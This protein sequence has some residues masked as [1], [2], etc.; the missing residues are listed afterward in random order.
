[1]NASI[2]DQYDNENICSEIMYSEFDE[3]PYALFDITTLQ[4]HVET[5][6]EINDINYESVGFSISSLST[7]NNIITVNLGFESSID[8][9]HFKLIVTLLNGNTLVS[10]IY[11]YK[12]ENVYY[13]SRAAQADGYELK[14]DHELN[15]NLISIE[16]YNTLIQENIKI[17]SDFNNQ[18]TPNNELADTQINAPS[19]SSAKKTTVV[20][21][22][23]W[24]DGTN[25][26]PLKDTLVK[27]YIEWPFEFG[28]SCSNTATLTTYTDDYGEYSFTFS[29][30]EEVQVNVQILSEGK[31]ILVK[32]NWISQS[33]RTSTP[34]QTLSP[35]ETASFYYFL[36]NESTT[37]KAFQVCQALI[38]GA[39]YV[40]DMGATVPDSTCY[41]P[42]DGDYYDGAINITEEAVEY[43]DIILHEYGHRLQE[44]FGISNNPGGNHIINEDQ[45]ANHGKDKGIRLAWGEGWPTCFAILVTQYYGSTLENIKDIN[46]N[47]YNS[48]SYD[49]NGQYYTWSYNIESRYS[50]GEGC[51]AAI[52]SVLYDFY[53]PYSASESWDNISLSHKDLFNAVINSNATTFS[54][55]YNYFINN[56]YSPNNGNVGKILSHYGMTS[57]ELNISSGTLSLSSPPTFSWV[58]GGTSA[59]TYNNFQLAFYNANNSVILTTERQTSTSLTLTTEQ[60]A[61]IMSASGTTFSVAVISF[62][63]NSPETGG[64]YS[65]K[66][67]LTKPAKENPQVMLNFAS[68]KRY[69]EKNI[70]LYAGQYYDY[71]IT[72]SSSGY[73]TIQTFGTT[74]TYIYLYNNNGALLAS[75]DDSGYGLNSLICFNVSANTQYKIRVKLYNSNA[76]GTTKLF[77]TPAYGALNSNISTLSTY[78]NIYSITNKTSYSWS[79]YAELNYTRMVTFTPPE[80]GSYTFELDSTFDNYLYVIDPRNSELL[81][82]NIDYNDDGGTGYNA[83]LTRYLDANVPYLII[84]SKYNPGSSFSNTDSTS[85]SLTI[86]K[87]GF[88]TVPNTPNY[89]KL[90]LEARSGFIIYNWDVKITNT[91]SFPVQITYNS[92]MCFESDAKNYTNLSDLVTIA[93]PANS[94][95]TVRING[96]GTA[97]WITTCVEYSVNSTN[98]RRITCANGLSGDLTMNTPYNKQMTCN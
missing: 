94:S 85:I 89:L 36:N 32:K 58:A 88:P 74:D 65:A 67:N 63:T 33:Y 13:L 54:E 44:Y 11:G 49:S 38:T 73:K 43:W 8:Y 35:G 95:V 39:H 70:T 81:I 84:Y 30:D 56:C 93:I 5:L 3:R 57:T 69:I 17:T 12:V 48:F 2:F 14:Y 59:S 97:G 68:S 9:A 72:F 47:L 64:Y 26:H 37:F 87:S 91:N 62:Q 52:F 98:Y 60:W 21:R 27:L 28:Q 46:D 40:E 86:N 41:F 55:F 7:V 16:E 92:K 50:E 29:T 24:S 4:F 53:D 18:T 79:S 80:E 61:Q 34:S 10:N 23:R 77:I 6:S 75:N 82:T 83:K 19:N 42:A 71:L 1:M 76:Y 78:E 96:N 45:I 31:N 51:E 15:N 66:L 20:G 22:W 25:L 90:E